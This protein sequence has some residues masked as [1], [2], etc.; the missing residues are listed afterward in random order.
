MINPLIE[1]SI[2]TRRLQHL[3]VKSK[4]NNQSLVKSLRTID[5]VVREQTELFEDKEIGE[6]IDELT[7]YYNNIL[8]SIREGTI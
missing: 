4:F 5:R 2:L 1:I 6:Q 7:E 3:M 8:D